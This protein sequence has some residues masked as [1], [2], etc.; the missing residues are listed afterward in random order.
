MLGREAVLRREPH[1]NPTGLKGGGLY[2]D[3]LTDDARLVIDVLESA[4]RAGALLGN[5]REVTALIRESG[6]VAGAEITDRLTGDHITVR[7]R[8][9]VN[10]AGPWVDRVLGL[11]RA[12]ENPT[13]RP[14]KGVHI[15]LR[16][17]DFPLRTAVFLRSP[18]DSRV[19]WPTP[20]GDGRHVYVG[21]TDTEFTGSLDDVVGDEEDF[22]YLL[23]AAN[24]ALP[25][26]H[27][28]SSHIVASWAGLRPLIAP[29]PGTSNS[30]ASR[31]HTVTVGA[32]GMITVAGGKLTT[33][34]LMAAQIVDTA[35]AQ[36]AD[37]WDVRGLPPSST[38]QV[39]ISGGA[40]GE[41]FR[42]RHALAAAPIA[43]AT[44]A[45]WLGR[46]GGNAALLAE[47]AVR[48]PADGEQ[49]GDGVLTPAEIRHAV[50]H[51]M[52]MTVSDVLARRTGSFF[53]SA[54]GGAAAIGQVS[55]VLDA[56]HGYSPQQRMR[57]QADYERWVARNRGTRAR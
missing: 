14:T 13:L 30:N 16:T 50:V 25:G 39:P 53:W 49:I 8:T 26:A 43:E 51:D 47:A 38:G 45:R 54:D 29:D 48:R 22:A 9:V 42:A 31:E 28:D 7:A 41:L 18:S 4:S 56:E 12:P 11:E 5:H 37:R 36:L 40:A 52:A 27:V 19:V 46:Y 24:H 15:V 35:A 23:E 17:E 2:H 57:Q 32:S 20:A 33:A 44:R 34:R 55:D 1:L 10:A 3:A 6:R 21:T